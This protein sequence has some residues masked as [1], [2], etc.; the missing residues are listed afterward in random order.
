MQMHDTYILMDWA[1]LLTVLLPDFIDSDGMHHLTSYSL[2]VCAGL[3]WM[4]RMRWGP[5]LTRDQMDLNNLQLGIPCTF[6]LQSS[7]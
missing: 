2:S 5:D 1:V 6:A 3:I 7:L 4:A